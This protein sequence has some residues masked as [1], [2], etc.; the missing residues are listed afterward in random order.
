MK[1]KRRFIAAVLMSAVCM[2]GGCGANTN[3]QESKSADTAKPV[4]LTV[5]FGTSYNDSR[6]KTI[7]AI[8]KAI[9]DAYPDYEVRRA[10]TSQTVIDIIK[11]RD[12][13]ETDN[14]EEA[15]DKLVSDGV[16]EVVVQPTHIMSGYEYDDLAAAVETYKDKFDKVAMGTPLLT[17]DEDY[18]NL[19]NAL[20]A[21]TKE[22]NNGETAIVFMGHGTEHDANSTYTKLQDS[23]TSAGADSYFVGTVEATPT[24]DDVIAAVKA[25]GYKKVVLEPLMVVAGDHANNDM[26]GDEDG[27]W[28]TTFEAEGY[29]VE[30]VLKGLGEIADV[31]KIY[32]SHV[33]DAIDRLGK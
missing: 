12:G 5:S 28:K 33:G 13:I 11:E 20:T 32:V 25:K 1:I 3:S 30:C 14:V 16:K 15:F 31:Q 26:A 9:A 6:E 21:E 10:F 22:Y 7:G 18:T 19:V 27:S 17:S 2:F 8:E 29:E 23:F 24:L 4:I